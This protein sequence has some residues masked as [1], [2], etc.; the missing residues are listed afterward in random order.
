MEIIGI[1]LTCYS[2]LGA[3]YLWSENKCRIAEKKQ[4]DWIRKQDIMTQ[5]EIDEL[6]KKA[7]GCTVFDVDLIDWNTTNVAEVFKNTQRKY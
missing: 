2:L 7:K 6:T 3:W 1:S 5:F 4:S